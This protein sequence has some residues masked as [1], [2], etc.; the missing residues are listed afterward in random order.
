MLCLMMN[1]KPPK[2]LLMRDRRTRIADRVRQQG[3]VRVDEL[4]EQFGVSAVT[5][6]GDLEQLEQLGVVIRDRG[7]AVAP[8][9]AASGLIAFDQRS[10]L[11]PDA[12]ARIGQAAARLVSPGD[13]IILDAGTTTVQMVSHLRELRQL[14]VITNALNVAFELRSMPDVRVVL[15][16]G[17]VNYETFSTHGTMTEQGLEA[18]VVQKLFLGAQS[19]ELEAGVTDTSSEIARVKRA[20]LK[21][22]RQ[23]ILVADSSKWQ[24]SGFIKVAPFSAIHTIVTDT[25]LPAEA[26]TAVQRAGSELILV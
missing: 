5:I 19:V 23:V 4:A 18:V 20:M 8:H 10:A 3:A 21:A 17:N 15:L 16:G 24:R 9:P 6:R 2:A 12:K 22:A 7:G 25:D 13:T 11:H 26:R 14:T 1:G